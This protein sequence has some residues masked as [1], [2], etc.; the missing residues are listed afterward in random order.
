MT[1]INLFNCINAVFKIL[2]RYEC[3]SKPG[4]SDVGDFMVFWYFIIPNILNRSTIS[5]TCHQHLWSPK[6]VTNI[7]VTKKSS[8]A[9]SMLVTVF[10]PTIPSILTLALTPKRCQKNVSNRMFHC[11]SSRPTINPYAKNDFMQ[12]HFD[13]REKPEFNPG[14]PFWISLWSLLDLRMPQESEFSWGVK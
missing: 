3:D 14:L 2:S 13:F 11:F 9:K 6:S 7:D 8:S 4:D 1:S 10:R 12:N 5:K